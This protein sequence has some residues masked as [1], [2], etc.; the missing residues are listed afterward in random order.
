[1]DVNM[2]VNMDVNLDV[3]TGA[4]F[5]AG[6]L[7]FEQKTCINMLLESYTWGIPGIFFTGH[8]ALSF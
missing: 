3:E 2:N 6:H 1:M 8:Y 7:G 5:H 4:T